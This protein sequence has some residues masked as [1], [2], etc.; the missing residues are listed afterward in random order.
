MLVLFVERSCFCAVLQEI[1][2]YL[3]DENGFVILS[4]APE[5]VSCLLLPCFYPSF[6]T[7]LI[8]NR[9]MAYICD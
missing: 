4:K 6:Q 8:L 7:T 5:E 9:E 1:D 3:L 2:C